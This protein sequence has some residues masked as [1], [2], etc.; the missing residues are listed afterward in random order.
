ME[1]IAAVD[2][3]EAAEF[4]ARFNE[5]TDCTAVLLEAILCRRLGPTV[6]ARLND[7]FLTVAHGS[8]DT[9]AIR[10][11]RHLVCPSVMPC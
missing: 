7:E 10:L 5:I 1:F 2:E 4:D 9:T 6:F 11:R 3:T 8:I